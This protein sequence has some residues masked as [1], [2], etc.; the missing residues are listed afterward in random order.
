MKLG[1]HMTAKAV[2]IAPREVYTIHASNDA[3]VG[4]VEWY[5]RWRQYVFDPEPG[6]V[7][8]HDCLAE[9]SAF[10][11]ARTK[12]SAKCSSCQHKPHRGLCTARSGGT[13]YGCMCSRQ[14]E[15]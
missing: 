13:A 6:G 1:K 5:P 9:L 10:C 3:I 4:T 14:E 12:E 2:G 11:A 7:F 8:S 15:P